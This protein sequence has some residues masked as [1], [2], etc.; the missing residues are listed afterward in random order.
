M[1]DAGQAIGCRL[2]AELLLVGLDVLEADLGIHRSFLSVDEAWCSMDT[3]SP[4]L[5]LSPSSVYPVIAFAALYLSGDLRAGPFRQRSAAL[6][7]ELG[8]P[9]F[10]AISASLSQGPA[11]A[12]SLAMDLG[13]NRG[14]RDAQA[15]IR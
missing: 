5:T 6:G 8:S 12:I 13:S 1:A 10:D 15:G 3:S 7:N 11:H 14:P 4:R 9:R 2:V